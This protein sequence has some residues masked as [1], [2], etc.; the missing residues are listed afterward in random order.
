MATPPPTANNSAQIRADFD[1][2][3]RLIEPLLVGATFSGP[4]AIVESAGRVQVERGIVF[5]H[6]VRG[7]SSPDQ[8]LAT[9]ERLIE[10][11][12]TVRA[13]AAW[14]IAVVDAAGHDRGPNLG[15][16]IYAWLQAFRLRYETLAPAEFGRWDEALRDWSD[17]IESRAFQASWGERT[18]GNPAS[19]GGQYAAAA[20]IGLA[21]HVAGKA[22]VRE[23]WTDLAGNIFQQLADAQR[24]TGAFLAAT[25][26]DNPETLW[27]HELSILHA[28]ASYAVQ[29]ENR[30][31]ARAVS[32]ATDFHLRETQPDHAS[33]QPWGL[34]AF[35][36]NPATRP[37]ADALLHAATLRS[38]NIDGVSLILL[39]DALYC[40]R[41]F[42]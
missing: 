28:A 35:I 37:T 10:L 39:A 31:T 11:A 26:S 23:G 20:W 40:L 29:A 13:Q 25:N 21:L 7:T 1:H 4:G 27:Y 12:R 24:D 6:A 17:S 15:L 30:D 22:F 41:L 19:R 32:R 16:L 36:W 42:L 9:V 2:Y 18:K 3:A 38:P 33:G 14:E 8:D 34:F 5:A